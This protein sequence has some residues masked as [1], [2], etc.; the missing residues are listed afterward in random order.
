[1]TSS[2]ALQESL[3]ATTRTLTTLISSIAVISLL[4]GGIGVMNIMLASVTERTR[5]IGVRM[6]MG[7]RRSDIVTQFLMEAV[8][9]CLTGG[10]IGVALALGGGALF[11]VLQEDIRLSNSS[12]AILLTCLS[13]SLIGIMLGYLPTRAASRLDPVEALARA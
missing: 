1:M 7:A 12:A 6:A 10:L 4:V 5:K 9:V 11:A 3:D 8:A 13:S 2:A